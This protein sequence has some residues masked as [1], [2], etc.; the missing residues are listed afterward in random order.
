MTLKH[1]DLFS[2]IGG[3]ALAAQWAGFTTVGF[4]EIDPFCSKVLRKH[5]P[6]VPNF[7]DVRS[8]PNMSQISLI[9]GGFPC[10]P[11][12][13]AGKKKGKEDE[14]YLW[15]EFR[16]IIQR[17]HPAWVVAENVPGIVDMERDSILTDLESEGYE[18]QTFIIPACAVK[19]PH[20][21]DRLWIVANSLRKRRH[22]G[23]DLVSAM[24]IQSHGERDFANV[25]AEWTEL[26]RKSWSSFNITKWLRPLTDTIGEQSRSQ[27]NTVCSEES[28]QRRIPTRE[29]SGSIVTSNA[30]AKSEQQKHSGSSTNSTPWERYTGTDRNG[31]SQL[32][33]QED[34]PPIPGVDV[35]LPN[36]LNRNKALGNAIVPQVV[37]P[38]LR[39]I[40][41]MEKENGTR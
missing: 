39:F 4:A 40:A 20:R 9:T 11:F 33:W 15:P 13:C 27:H 8:V 18:T 36:G 29:D 12:S 5:W 41:L 32:N 24:R 16:R 28:E 25:S 14:R 2:G 31:T 35:R 6:N 26:F 37:Y 23:L 7:G 34:E 10:Q 21:R 1:L 38:I 19:A 30:Y 22:G 17:N 3:F